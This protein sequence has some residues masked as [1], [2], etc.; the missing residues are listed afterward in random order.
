MLRPLVRMGLV[1]LSYSPGECPLLSAFIS[2]LH[3]KAEN[4]PETGWRASPWSWR[5]A[6]TVVA[7][8]G[9]SGVGVTWGTT[10]PSWRET[11]RVTFASVSAALSKPVSHKRLATLAWPSCPDCPAGGAAALVARRDVSGVSSDTS[12]RFA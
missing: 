8:V 12:R 2:S 1:F 3:V 5:P 6:G 9:V 7:A 11:P 4:I 10:S